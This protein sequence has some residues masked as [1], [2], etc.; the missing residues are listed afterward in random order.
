MR[1]D[2]LKT[3][4]IIDFKTEFRPYDLYVIVETE[5]S[6]FEFKRLLKWIDDNE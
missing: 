3:S 2:F 6:I 4:N 1:F 5:N